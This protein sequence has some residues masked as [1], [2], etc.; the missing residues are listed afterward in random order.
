MKMFNRD[1]TGTPSQ[2][3]IDLRAAIRPVGTMGAGL[4]LAGMV[5]ASIN[6]YKPDPSMI[7][8]LTGVRYS[9]EVVLSSWFGSRLSIT[10]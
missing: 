7:D 2:W 6:G 9:C 1:I 8:T 4:I 10:K 5:W 3:I